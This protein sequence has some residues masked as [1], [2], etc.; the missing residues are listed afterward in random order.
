M[1]KAGM[2]TAA[3]VAIMACLLSGVFRSESRTSVTLLGLRVAASGS[4]QAQRLPNLSPAE[5]F[6]V[7][8]SSPSACVA[9][10]EG[11]SLAGRSPRGPLVLSLAGKHWQQQAA[12]TLALSPHSKDP[13]GF[14]GVDCSSATDCIAV[15]PYYPAEARPLADSWDG[16]SW[17]LAPPAPG[18]WPV[19]LTAV[20]CPQGDDCEAVGQ[21]FPPPCTR[22]CKPPNTALVEVWDGRSWHM[23]AQP[24]EAVS[25]GL[26]GVSCPSKQYCV[27]V[28]NGSP[29]R[30]DGENWQVQALPLA[31]DSVSCISS[32]YCVAVGESA[33]GSSTAVVEKWDGTAWRSQH[34]P[35]SPKGTVNLTSVSCVSR[36]YCVA[37]GGVEGPGAYQVRQFTESWDGYRWQ[38]GSVLVGQ[39][40]ML[41]SVSCTSIGNCV[42][43][44]FEYK[45]KSVAPL[46]ERLTT[47]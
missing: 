38:T 32:E 27:T 31:L 24:K 35:G 46:V 6:G 22:P 8:C 17:R 42:A 2:A 9:V 43:V 36:T 34:A 13:Y 47:I 41:N 45:D 15:G 37:V 40:S 39:G 18:Q 5:L 44:G 26:L 23:Q 3:V 21:S 25:Q 11:L 7:S 14:R 20:S 16:K 10:G 4:W 29:E 33:E 12:P 19:E 1:R 30:W 28:G